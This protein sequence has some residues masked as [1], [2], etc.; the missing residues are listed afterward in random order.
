MPLNWDQRNTLNAR[1][2]VGEPGDWTVGLIFQYGS[3]T[4]YTE[5][6][7]IS[8]GVRFENGGVKP[9]FYNLDLRAEKV[10][11]IGGLTSTLSCWFIMY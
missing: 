8:K 9:E 1:V 7:R 6:I 2:T 5:D 11:N 4:P 3:G 10:F